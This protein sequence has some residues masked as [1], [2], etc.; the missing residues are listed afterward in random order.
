MHW[1]QAKKTG[2]NAMTPTQFIA[3]R[4][5]LGYTSQ[6]TLAKALDMSEIQVGRYERGETPISKRTELALKSLKKA[7]S[8][9]ALQER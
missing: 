9:A 4:K 7:A 3:Q 5:A 1:T 8:P 2:I 6:A